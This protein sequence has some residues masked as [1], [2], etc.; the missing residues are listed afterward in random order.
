MNIP[1]TQVIPLNYGRFCKKWFPFILGAVFMFNCLNLYCQANKVLKKAT[2]Q[3]SFTLLP[4]DSTG[5]FFRNDVAVS[6]YFSSVTYLNAY[7]GGGVAAGDLNNDGLCDLVFTS[8]QKGPS[9]YINKGGMKFE[10]ITAKSGLSRTDGWCTGVTLVDINHDGWLDIYI[11]RSGSDETKWTNLL[12]I[13][14][15]NGTF[16]EQAKKYGLQNNQPCTQAYFFDYDNDGDL[17]VYLVNHPSVF[18]RY[19]FNFYAFTD[20][21]LNSLGKDRLMENIG[22]TFVDVSDKA[23]INPQ[24]SYGLSAGVAD[25]NN[26][27]YPD[28]YVANDFLSPD[29]FYINNGDKTFTEKTSEYFNET[30]LSAMGSDFGDLNNDGYQ[31]LFVVDM[32]PDNHLRMKTHYKTMPLEWYQKLHTDKEM[33]PPQFAENSFQLSNGGKFFSQISLVTG[34][35]KTDWS[36]DVDID[37]L[38]NDGLNDIFI[39]QGIKSD[40][41]DLDY[42][43]LQRDTNNRAGYHHDKDSVEIKM[44]STKFTNRVFMNQGNLNFS[45]ETLSSGLVEKALS[46][47]AVTAD[48]DNDGALELIVNNMDDFA[49]IYKNNATQDITKHFLRIKLEGDSLNKFGIGTVVNIYTSAGMQHKQLSNSRGFESCPEQMIHFGL[50]NITSVDS[51]VVK[52]YDRTT[53]TLYNVAANQLLTIKKKDA[54]KYV[55]EP[56]T[57]KPLITEVHPKG[58]SNVHKEDDFN[59]Y[60]KD[61]LLP[62]MLSRE[63]PAIATGDVNNDGLEDVFIGGAYNGSTGQLLIQQKDGSFLL[64]Q[65]QP[66]KNLNIE[67]TG[68]V[69]ADF[70]GDGYLDLYLANGSNEFSKDDT[71]LRD[72]LYLNKAGKGFTDASYMLP[73]MS[74]VKTSPVAFDFN[75]DGKMDLFVA[76]RMMPGEY[77]SSSRS[78]LLRNDGAQFTDVTETLC[79]ELAKTGNACAAWAGDLNKDGKPDLIVASEWQPLMF[80]KNTG[81]TFTRVLTHSPLDTLKGWWK[82]IVAADLNTDG[83]IDFLVGNQGMNSY[84]QATPAEPV[85][86]YYNDFDDNG[87]KEPLVTHYLKGELGLLYDRTILCEQMPKF[88]KRFLTYDTYMHTGMKNI[89]TAEKMKTS[90]KYEVNFL[91][92]IWIE[93]MGNFH[94]KMHELPDRVQW[95]PA[96]TFVVTDLNGDNKPDIIAG[97]NS[98][99]DLYW[100][101]LSSSS[102]GVVMLNNGKNDFVP[103]DAAKSGF[104]NTTVCR[105]LQVMLING[106]NKCMLVANNNK[107]LRVFQLPK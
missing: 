79:P 105:H 29:H 18:L 13:N 34:T 71:L 25:V 20:S 45:D 30:S 92:S 37:D 96:N 89:F 26:D 51:I 101:G 84:L 95:A 77:P 7:N 42:T 39:T 60:T 100:A 107:E 65:P 97:E 93:N 48:L 63:G 90:E 6:K 9:V 75:G 23:G 57:V 53:Q 104:F 35:A 3:S 11:C 12:Y 40:Y 24:L 87:V 64:A 14:N 66:W 58:F 91:K 73:V 2:K 80:Y 78:Y 99:A 44:P 83:K 68:A 41:L 22:D 47:G 5:I 82:C 46:N 4:P 61:R 1:H 72:R 16:T 36:W 81:K 102:P 62:F 76:G 33:Q 38:N 98:E 52:W 28:L 50:D 32:L 86:L 85:T 31:D 43:E 69:F 56:A 67:T 74:G 59:D 70:N 106:L 94:F 27:G 103:V 10:D 15:H 19:S 17:D 49:Y 21:Q 8:N 88:K 55:D 54:K